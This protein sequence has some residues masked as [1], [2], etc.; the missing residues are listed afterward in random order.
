MSAIAWR[1]YAREAARHVELSWFSVL[2][3][4]RVREFYEHAAPGTVRSLAFGKHPGI[5]EATLE[6]FAIELSPLATWL[7][8]VHELAHLLEWKENANGRHDHRFARRVAALAKICRTCEFPEN[9]LARFLES[10]EPS[11]L[12]THFT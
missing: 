12:L 10:S 9:D 3:L 7:D 1:Y 8:A 6:T 5:S 4:D 11:R 2:S